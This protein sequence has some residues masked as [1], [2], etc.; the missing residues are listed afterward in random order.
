MAKRPVD[1]IMPMVAELASQSYID[2]ISLSLKIVNNVIA[3][4]EKHPH[5]S[6]DCF[7]FLD[8][9]KKNITDAIELSKK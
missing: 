7:V 3:A 9:V 5:T 2:G 4:A 1:V 6:K 8:L